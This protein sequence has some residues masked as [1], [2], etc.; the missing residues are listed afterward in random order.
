LCQGEQEE[1]EEYELGENSRR[2]GEQGVILREKGEEDSYARK[3][4]DPV[5]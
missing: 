3:E 4:T 5:I 1:G 2:A